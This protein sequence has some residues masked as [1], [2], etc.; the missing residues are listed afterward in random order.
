MAVWVIWSVSALPL[1]AHAPR[2]CT[3]FSVALKHHGVEVAPLLHQ[4]SY[5]WV[6]H[7]I[8]LARQGARQTVRTQDHCTGNG[9]KDG[10][11]DRESDRWTTEVQYIRKDHCQVQIQR[12]DYT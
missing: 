11:T 8:G 4:F 7:L 6:T 12:F 2:A 10:Q 3:P 1:G 9:W 5:S